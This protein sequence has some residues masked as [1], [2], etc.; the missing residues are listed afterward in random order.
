MEIGKREE[1]GREL[2]VESSSLQGLSFSSCTCSPRH[3]G[4]NLFYCCEP[5]AAAVNLQ[6]IKTVIL[7][8]QTGFCRGWVQNHTM[9][10]LW[11]MSCYSGKIYSTGE[12]SDA[13]K[14]MVT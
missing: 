7:A 13:P 3:N 9:T 5:V 6:I 12:C 8:A 10:C 2:H 1:L 4:G 11:G 14:Q